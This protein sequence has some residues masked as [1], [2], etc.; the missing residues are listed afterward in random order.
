MTF[1]FTPVT[2]KGVA[3]KP[4][5]ENKLCYGIDLRTETPARKINLNYLFKMYRAYPEKE[6]FLIPIFDV[7]AATL[8]LKQQVQQ[9]WLKI[10]SAK[11]GSP[12]WIHT[13]PCEKIPAVSIAGWQCYEIRKVTDILQILDKLIPIRPSRLITRTHTHYWLP[14]CCRHNVPMFA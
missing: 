7:L 9:G 12:V 14:C 4:P 13:M 10:K 3:V 8:K 6:K 2:I 11:R 5:H 1:T